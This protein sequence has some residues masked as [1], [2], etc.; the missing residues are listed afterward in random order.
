MSAD[1]TPASESL[2][3]KIDSAV[4]EWAQQRGCMV[5]AYAG[6]F[7]YMQPD[8]TR[9]WAR[10][11]ADEQTHTTTL[12]ILRFHTLTIEHEVHEYLDIP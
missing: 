2:T 10:V 11:S 9:A 7:Q 3:S 8:G 4:A 1:Q 12:G 5:T 6:L